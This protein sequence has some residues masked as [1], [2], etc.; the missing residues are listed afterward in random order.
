VALL[1]KVIDVVPPSSQNGAAV[2]LIVGVGGT[3]FT[4]INS[5]S[6]KFA[7]QP[8]TDGVATTVKLVDAV[9]GVTG[10]TNVL[11]LPPTVVLTTAEVLSITW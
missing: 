4:V 9:V 8:A 3:G 1:V 11:P 5:T 6:L 2:P 7:A 10:M